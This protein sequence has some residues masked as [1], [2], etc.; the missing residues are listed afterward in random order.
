[1]RKLSILLLI[2]TICLLS[3]C[4]EDGLFSEPS[5]V[6]PQEPATPQ[7]PL[8]ESSGRPA[9]PMPAATAKPANTP[10]SVG[11]PLTVLPSYTPEPEPTSSPVPTATAI[12][13]EAAQ[14]KREEYVARCKH[15]ALRNLE[16]IEYSKFER[17]DPY[18]MTDLERVLWGIV[19]V[20][21]EQVQTTGQ[22]YYGFSSDGEIRFEKDYLEWCQDYWSEA[23]SEA[24]ANKRNHESWE[25]S[26]SMLLVNQG[27]SIEEEAERS[28][29]NYADDGMS[30]IIVNQAIRC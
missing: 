17:L 29:E 21:Q 20:D 13:S 24:N 23:L 3:A 28:W 6:P 18:N 12:T 25:V 8:R 30:P 2:L 11:T 19:L 26:C 27:R 10:V 15:W 16:P 5:P 1:M 22:Y 14:S 7:S 9:T 4:S